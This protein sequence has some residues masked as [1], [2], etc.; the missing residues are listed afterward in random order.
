MFFEYEKEPRRTIFCID[1]KSFYA[2]VECVARGYDPLE[3]MLVVMSHAENSG[4]LVLASSP[5]AKEILGIT[6][7]TRKYDVPNHPELE[8]VPP[9]MNEYIKE[10]MKI[11]DIYSN[12]VADEDLHIYSI[13]ESFLDVTASWKLFGQ[14][15]VELARK[16]QK[17]IQKETGLYITIGIGDNPLLAKLAMDI[18]AKHTDERLAEWHYEDVPE[19]VW[20]IE[21]MTEM[22]GIGHRLARRLNNLGIRSVY[23]LAHTD[24]NKLKRNL[25]IIGEQLYAHAHGID[26]SR[27]SEKYIPEERSFNNSQILMRDY[28]RQEEIEVVIREMADQVAARLRKAHCQTECVHLS[29]GVSRGTKQEN[30]GFS[31][32]MKV[33]LT[34]SSKLL[35]DYCLMIF[36]QYWRGEEVRHIGITYS[37]LN[38]NTYVQLD[39]FH[40]PTEQLKELELDHVIDDIRQRFGYVSLVHASS[41]TKGGTA[42]SRASLVGGHAGG[43][44][45]LE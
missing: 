11:N 24:I 22:W 13:D 35:I 30:T 2:S 45:G 41:M 15:P 43:L 14:S 5:K 17:R 37:K 10:N 23:E 31:R 44:E 3:K 9:R 33:P 4:G 21:P 39:L 38:Y 16:I 20:T 36:R 6:N 25:G 18:E 32:Q 1:V 26:R 34:N 12:Y 29:V 42:I 19:K 27:L 7:V 40:E 28:L 8:I